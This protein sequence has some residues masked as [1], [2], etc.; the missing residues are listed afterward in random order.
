MACRL[1]G[2]RSILLSYGRRYS[3]YYSISAAFVQAEICRR[4][5]CRRKN[6]SNRPLVGMMWNILQK[7]RK[8][9]GKAAE[10][11]E[12]CRKAIAILQLSMYNSPCQTVA[13]GGEERPILHGLTARAI[14]KGD[15]PYGWLC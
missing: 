14:L 1:G 12:K 13:K 9:S 3:V 11:H 6:R 2:D 8:S 7:I 15:I 5:Q 4:A 10:I